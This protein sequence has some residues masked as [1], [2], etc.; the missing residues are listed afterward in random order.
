MSRARFRCVLTDWRR[1]VLCGCTGEHVT[2]HIAVRRG[3]LQ[4]KA[5]HGRAR[6]RRLGAQA[7]GSAED[8]DDREDH[9]ARGSSGLGVPRSVRS[10]AGTRV[11]HSTSV[12]HCSRWRRW[13]AQEAWE[14]ARARARVPSTFNLSVVDGHGLSTPSTIPPF[15]SPSPRGDGMATFSDGG[16]PTHTHHSKMSD[17]LSHSSNTGDMRHY[18]QTLLDT[19]EKQLQQ[20][21]AL[22]QRVLAQQVELEERVRQL[23]EID[24]DKGED[25]EIDADM[26]ERYRQ[27]AESVSTWEAENVQLSSAF[28]SKVCPSLPSLSLSFVLSLSLCIALCI[29]LFWH[30]IFFR[31]LLALLCRPRSTCGPLRK[32]TNSEEFPF[33]FRSFVPSST[34]LVSSRPAWPVLHGVRRQVAHDPAIASTLHGDAVRCDDDDYHTTNVFSASADKQ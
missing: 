11:C 21:G 20:A 5:G 9:G 29:V 7:T 26:R 34:L 22:G 10:R 2:G 24:A 13:R 15:S 4:R 3:E 8:V 6:G 12:D 23:Q 14:R 28:G 27:L 32:K 1:L 31:S 33:R 16:L 19:K 18:L 17:F 30:A 25:V